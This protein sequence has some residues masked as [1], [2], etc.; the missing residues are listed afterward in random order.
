[1]AGVVV[2]AEVDGDLDV[3][4]VIA[5]TRQAA[6][7]IPDVPAAHVFEGTAHLPY[8]ERPVEVAEM[9]RAGVNG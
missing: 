7:R 8:L 9:I 3:P 5:R 2:T 4:M 6:G 1:M